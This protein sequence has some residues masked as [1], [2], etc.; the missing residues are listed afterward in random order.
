MFSCEF[1]K[2][3]KNTFFY[4]TP[5]VVSYVLMEYRNGKQKTVNAE[6]SVNVHLDSGESLRAFQGILFRG[7][8]KKLWGMFK[9]SLNLF[10]KIFTSF[11][12]NFCEFLTKIL[13]FLE[14]YRLQA[15]SFLSLFTLRENSNYC[16]WSN[17][18]EKDQEVK[19][20]L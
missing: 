7:L 10:K 13:G 1:Y 8:F 16:E 4:R 20:K 12:N 3:S 11:Q 9:K 6:N 5:L 18:C 2:I 17:Y 19:Q 14:C 15:F